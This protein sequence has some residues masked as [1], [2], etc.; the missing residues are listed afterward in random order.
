VPELKKN[1]ATGMVHG[2]GDPL[3]TGHLL[4]SIDTGRVGTARALL[5]NRRGFGDDQ[6]R[7]RPLHIVLSH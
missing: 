6:A 2:V 5:G 4:V 7:R 3:P 1:A